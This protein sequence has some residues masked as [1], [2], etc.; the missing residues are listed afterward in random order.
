MTPGT[1][2][3]D[4]T[5]VFAT[6]VLQFCPR[7]NPTDQWRFLRD[8]LLA[9]ATS[10]WANVEEARAAQSKRDVLA[11]MSIALKA[12]REALYW[13]R[14]AEDEPGS[15]DPEFARLKDEADQIVAILTAT[16]KTTR[17]RLEER[18]P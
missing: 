11:K 15:A 5:R 7:P 17:Q 10:V 14:V 12:A 4:R 2:F 3:R 1:S 9:S 13:L 18:G 8:Q 16:V 6:R